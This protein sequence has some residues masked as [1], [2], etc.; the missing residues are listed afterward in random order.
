MDSILTLQEQTLL[1]YQNV[2]RHLFN[3]QQTVT[4]ADCRDTV[5]TKLLEEMQYSFCETMESQMEII[6]PLP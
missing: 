5:E 2:F 6:F 3:S 1:I 4:Y